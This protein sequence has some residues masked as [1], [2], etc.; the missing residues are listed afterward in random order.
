MALFLPPVIFAVLVWYVSTGVIIWL[1]N[2]PRHTHGLSMAGATVVLAAC[3]F[4]LQ[5]NAA[6]PS[7]AGVYLGF[8]CGLLIWGWQEMSFFTGFV[9][10]PRPVPC[11][12]GCTG[13][14][15]FGRAVRAC[16]YH[17]MA[18]ALTA[19]VVVTATLGAGN[20]TATWTFLALWALRQSAKFNV[21]LGVRNLS[22]EFVP[23]HLAFIRSFLRQRPMNLLFPLSVT[24]GTGAA[25]ML[26]HRA[27]APHVSAAAA[28]R[29]TMLATIVTLG[30]IE[31]WFLVL[32]LPFA[33]LWRWSLRAATW[34]PGRL[35]L[36]SAEACLPTH[37]VGGDR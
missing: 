5:A 1:D 11:P 22:E 19:L 10:G 31:H 17:E 30:V 34:R 25:I 12:P 33:A 27:A 13:W 7:V 16:L 18:I 6:D 26:G 35:N 2:L 29:L 28:T 36:M 3:L 8:V 37:P 21:F 9:T 4:A 14:A 20:Q 24:L 23:E 15:R 32:P